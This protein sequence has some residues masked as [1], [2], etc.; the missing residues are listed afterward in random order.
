MWQHS[1]TAPSA[2]NH[3]RWI[4]SVT[5]ISVYPWKQH[6]PCLNHRLQPALSVCSLRSARCVSTRPFVSNTENSRWEPKCPMTGIFPKTNWTVCRHCGKRQS[7]A[8]GRNVN[9]TV[10]PSP[11]GALEL[12]DLR[13]FSL[14]LCDIDSCY[15]SGNQCFSFLRGQLVNIYIIRYVVFPL[16]HALAHHS[17]TNSAGGD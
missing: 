11:T 5:G 14:I 8:N 9:I 12:R 16:Y 2:V 4:Y 6:S 3:L 10:S 15:S 13:R 7:G 1:W 17:A